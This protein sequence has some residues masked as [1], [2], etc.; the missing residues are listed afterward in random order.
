MI[1]S[2]F[3]FKDWDTVSNDDY[4][5]RACLRS[6]WRNLYKSPYYFHLLYQTALGILACLPTFRQAAGLTDRPTD[7]FIIG[8]SVGMPRFHLASKHVIDHPQ[9]IQPSCPHLLGRCF[10]CNR[11]WLLCVWW[12][13]DRVVR[14]Q[15]FAPWSSIRRYEWG[16]S[17]RYEVN[18]NKT[19]LDGTGR[20]GKV[21]RS[22][23]AWDGARWYRIG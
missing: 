17:T 1:K 12:T 15:L 7:W 6:M 9:R 10:I 16:R 18:P 22:I 2:T 8:N 11:V 14:H 19:Q 5:I 3:Y 21:Q 20:S 23:V 4:E 13:A